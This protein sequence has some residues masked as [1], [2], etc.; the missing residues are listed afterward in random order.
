MSPSAVT[1]RQAGVVNAQFK[2]QVEQV[3]G[4]IDNNQKKLDHI[5]DMVVDR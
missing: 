5:K 3:H 4:E 2:Q 1:L